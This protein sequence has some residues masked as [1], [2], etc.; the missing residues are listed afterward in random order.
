[1]DDLTS[2][3]IDI[4]TPLLKPHTSPLA[5]DDKDKYS[6][7]YQGLLLAKTILAGYPYSNEPLPPDSYRKLERQL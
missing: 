3:I 1:M 6:S 2:M 5:R 4:F 7:K